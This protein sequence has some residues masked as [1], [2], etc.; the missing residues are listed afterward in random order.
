M[1]TKTIQLW[2]DRDDARV[3]CYVLRDSPEFRA[4]VKRPAV[5]VCPGGAYLGTSDR[6]AEPVALRFA[7]AGYHAFVL[8]YTTYY[9]GWV[10]DWQNPPPGNERS[11]Y[12]QPLLELAKTVALVRRHADEWRVDPNRIAVAGFSAGGHLAASLGVHWHEAFL[13]EQLGEDNRSFKPNALILGYPVLDYLLMRDELARE[14]KVEHVNLFRLANQ[15]VFGTP[16]PDEEQ[17]AARSPALHVPDRTPP[18]FIWHT[19]DDDLVYAQNALIFASACARRKVPYELHVFAS[20]VHGLSLADETT[21]AYPDQINP[22]AAVW[23]QLALNWLK[24]YMK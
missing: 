4:G 23:F 24:K 15:A 3:E 18:V 9:N 12:P 19:A 22:E 6:E 14:Q 13:R 10:S 5:I 7:A 8:R 21:A 16:E 1:L 11:A 17:L 20:G 2:E